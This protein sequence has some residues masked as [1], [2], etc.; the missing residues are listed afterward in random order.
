[1]KL[2]FMDGFVVEG[3]GPQALAEAL[4]VSSF[5]PEETLEDYMR[6]VARRCLRYRMVLVAH[7]CPEAF[8][9]D[10]LFWDFA[11]IVKEEEE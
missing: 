6:E 9:R 4:R 10:L 7:H 3:E 11:E 8:I 1:M 2:R 5:N